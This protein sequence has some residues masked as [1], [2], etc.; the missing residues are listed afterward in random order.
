MFCCFDKM[1]VRFF[2]QSRSLRSDLVA[3]VDELGERLFCELNYLQEA[4]NCIK[5]RVRK[6]V[7]SVKPDYIYVF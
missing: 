5:F 6:C 4:Q 2:S 1:N 3:I 7:Y